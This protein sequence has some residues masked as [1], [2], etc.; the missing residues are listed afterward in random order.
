M[1]D[2]KPV[3]SILCQTYN[4][5]PYIRECIEGF[6]MQKTTFNFVVFIHDDASTDGTAD[7]IR[8]YQ[9]KYPDIIKPIYQSINQWS[10]G[11]KVFSG[12]Q[13]PRVKSQYIAWC[14]GD[15]YW[16]DP[17]KLQKQVDFLEAHPDYILVY[18][19]YQRY[20]QE[21]AMF[22]PSTD[23]ICEGMVYEEL[24]KHTFNIQT[25]TVCFRKEVADS[26]LNTDIPE[27]CF[28]GDWADYLIAS[29]L[30]K[31]KFIPEITAVYRVLS[32]SASHFKSKKAEAI[33]TSKYSK[34]ELFFWSKYPLAD[35]QENRDAKLIRSYAVTKASLL[36]GDYSGMCFVDLPW[37][38]TASWGRWLVM[39]LAKK[40]IFFYPMSR[41]LRLIDYDVLHKTIQSLKAYF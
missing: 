19:D 4:H 7:I 2:Q 34:T 11:N 13:L 6:L 31:F 24:L 30:G 3:V 21:K 37:R 10:L 12:I 26:I 22:I 41:L 33:F 17:Y 25:P 15:D 16:T 27:G 9:E 40:K 1:N 36:A 18:T 5:A 8:E 28:T 32:E 35:T 38:K 29:R 20:I 23:K 39:W 14:D